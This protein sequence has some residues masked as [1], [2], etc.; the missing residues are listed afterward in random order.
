MSRFHWTALVG[1]FRN[2][3]ISLAW[4]AGVAKLVWFV[5]V[6]SWN[7]DEVSH[8]HMAW[9][10]SVGEVPYRDFA[11]NHFPF[12]WVPVS[13]VMRVLPES[14][15]GLTVLRLLALSSNLVFLGALGTFIAQGLPRSRWIWTAACFAPVVFSRDALHFLMEFRPDAL[16]NALLF[17]AL[18]WLGPRGERRI[19][20]A[21]ACGLLIGAAMLINTKY[22][23][24]PVILG[25]T[26]VC[27]HLRELRK[28]WRT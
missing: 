3:I 19:S 14:S 1:C 28:R 15:A 21:F 6:R 16:A 22:L 24:F 20:A 9:L 18:A 13:F 11:I 17:G 5:F 26:W 8:A 25:L 2:A 7:Y 23:L 27:A 4:V 10:L 12:F